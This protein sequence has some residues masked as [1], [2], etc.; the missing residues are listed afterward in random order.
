MNATIWAILGSGL[1]IV[2]G[3]MK[4]LNRKNKYRI[5][6]MAQAQKELEDAQKNGDTSAF[7]AAIDKLNCLR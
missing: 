2:L 6:Q 1:A 3:L 7:T 4:Y 5:E